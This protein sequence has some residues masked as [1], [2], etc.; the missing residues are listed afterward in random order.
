VVA[1]RGSELCIYLFF[2]E[3]LTAT[4]L[5]RVDCCIYFLVGYIVFCDVYYYRGVACDQHA[6]GLDP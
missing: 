3:N 6:D 2:K 5:S 1:E 4:V